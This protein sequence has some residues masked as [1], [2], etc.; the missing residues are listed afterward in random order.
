MW[1]VGQNLQKGVAC[2]GEHEACVAIHTEESQER[3]ENNL[4][5]LA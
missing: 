1:W 3:R 5:R 4:N 2:K